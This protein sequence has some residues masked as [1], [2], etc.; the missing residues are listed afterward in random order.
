MLGCV[1]L[2]QPY[3]DVEQH[4]NGAGAGLWV[5]VRGRS[6]P[7]LS[8]AA[9]AGA[10]PQRDN[11]G[12]GRRQGYGCECEDGAGPVRRITPVLL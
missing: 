11:I 6:G 9:S 12:M 7:M 4:W 2:S 1:E 10:E 5:G 8:G 3:A